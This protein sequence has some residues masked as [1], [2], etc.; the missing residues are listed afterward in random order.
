MVRALAKHFGSRFDLNVHFQANDSFISSHKIALLIILKV[1]NS[2]K[3]GPIQVWTGEKA[4]NSAFPFS[5]FPV[6][7]PHAVPF[8]KIRKKTFRLF[9]VQNIR[10]KHRTDSFF[11]VSRT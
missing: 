9:P 5:G 2:I 1:Y 6:P 8:Y 3:T 7:L 11:P 4:E 10:I